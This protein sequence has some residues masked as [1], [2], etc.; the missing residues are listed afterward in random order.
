MRLIIDRF[1]GKIAVCESTTGNQTEI[2]V[3]LLP[4]GVRSGDVL[5]VKDGVFVVDVTET[6]ARK[7]RII[8]LENALF[9]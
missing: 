3:E 8:E 1:E 5:I 4:K 7:S 2:G 9:E 6:A